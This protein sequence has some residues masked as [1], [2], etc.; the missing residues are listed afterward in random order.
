[1][2]GGSLSTE[3]WPL[4]GLFATGADLHRRYT[5]GGMFR[6]DTSPV[7]GRHQADTLSRRDASSV[8]M[9]F[10]TDPTT[11]L[12]GQNMSRRDTSSVETVFPTDPQCPF[13]GETC[14]AGTTAR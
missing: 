7:K 6:R 4:K 10:P 3:L 2:G 5:E 14:P 12:Q 11:P 13:R 8:E 1:M 9:A